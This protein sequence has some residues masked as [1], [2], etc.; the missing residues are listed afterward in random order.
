VTGIKEGDRVFGT[1]FRGAFAERV[2]LAAVDIAR[3]LGARRR[4]RDREELLDLFAAGRLT[5]HIGARFPLSGAAAALR[6]VADRRALG[7]VV[8]DIQCRKPR[9]TPSSTAS[10]LYNDVQYLSEVMTW[11]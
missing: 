1:V 6:Y 3:E 10:P 7:K 8:I 11:R 4:G 2:R 5:P 9:T